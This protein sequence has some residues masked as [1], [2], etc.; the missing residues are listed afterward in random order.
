MSHK[1]NLQDVKDAFGMC[2]QPAG[3]KQRTLNFKPMSAEAKL[4][5]EQK[6]EEDSRL[7]AE[8]TVAGLTGVAQINLFSYMFLHVFEAS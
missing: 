2:P 7:T 6:F 5:H 4:A 1:K 3:K 8:K